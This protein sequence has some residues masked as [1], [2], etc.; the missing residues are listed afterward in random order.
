[1]R[2]RS[3]AERHMPWRLIANQ[4]SL[5][6]GVK[7][8]EGEGAYS[9]GEGAWWWSGGDTR[10][11]AAR[12]GRRRRRRRTFGGRGLAFGEGSGPP[13]T[14]SAALGVFRGA[15]ADAVSVA[16]PSAF[17]RPPHGARPRDARPR[18]AQRQRARTSQA[19]SAPPADLL[20]SA[21]ASKKKSFFHDY[22]FLFIYI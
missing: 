5:A 20:A 22:S 21:A 12:C 1:M 6:E 15:V 9:H 8:R 10:V 18:D 7:E 11:A 13:R 16:R 17:Q 19:A 3:D 2:K 4:K 14:T